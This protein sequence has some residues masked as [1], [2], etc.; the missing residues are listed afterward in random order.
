MRLS[1]KIEHAMTAAAQRPT[2][3]TITPVARNGVMPA[4]PILLGGDDLTMI[5]RADRAIPFA[6]A[7]DGRPAQVSAPARVRFGDARLPGAI[8]DVVKENSK[9][10]NEFVRCLASTRIEYN[11]DT[12]ADET[13]RRAE[14]AVPLKLQARVTWDVT[15]GTAIYSA[16]AVVK[17]LNSGV[18]LSYIGS[19]GGDGEGQIMIFDASING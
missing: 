5:V 3:A 10:A 15:G 7:A 4:R 17:T 2:A 11:T 8:A 18:K 19:L 9:L 6:R 14:S 13:L 16:A 1:K 12:A